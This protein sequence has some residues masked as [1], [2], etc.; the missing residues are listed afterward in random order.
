MNSDLKGGAQ[1]RY[2]AARRA[3]RSVASAFRTVRL[4]PLHH[5]ATVEALEAARAAVDGYASAY[6]SLLVTAADH[7][8]VFDA[9]GAPYE[10]D[11]VA[12][13]ARALRARAIPALRFLRGLPASELGILLSALHLPR[14]Q[15]ERSG[16]LAALLASRGVRGIVIGDVAAP[17]A[18]G[19]DL[20]EALVEAAG[21][22]ATDRIDGYL[23]QTGGSEETI[24]DLLRRLDRRIVT[25]PRAE[26][27]AAWRAV[28]QSLTSLR[29]AWQAA[30]C[31]MVVR[32]VDEPWAASIA[33]QWPPVLAASL[34]AQAAPSGA[35][36]Q[37]RRV[38]DVLRIFKQTRPSVSLPAPE[39]PDPD[40]LRR[41]AADAAWDGRRLR[42]QAVRRLGELLPA[43]EAGELEPALADLE[44][45]VVTMA[46]EGDGAGLLAA[47]STAAR[48]A[49]PPGDVRG[50][51]LRAMTRRVLSLGSRDLAAHV[52]AG[53]PGGDHLL[54][55]AMRLAPEETVR[56]LRQALGHPDAQLRGAAARHVTALRRLASRGGGELP[57]DAAASLARIEEGSA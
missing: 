14:A 4:Y 44:A 51:L 38:A 32:S 3:A 20:L 29:A 36:A 31:A 23:R 39:A 37:G 9:A 2:E 49:V 22:G 28:G 12:E 35:R 19:A 53:A 7:G 47:L 45:A 16:G 52:L 50:D 30:V 10:D 13:L 21:A 33:A 34:A 40:A 43:M 41:A 24:R 27:A 1:A 26:Q 56:L 25:R 48:A 11:V 8:L 17:Q 57:D 18:A 42:E 15:L 54:V 5:A 55:R 6:G 46:Q